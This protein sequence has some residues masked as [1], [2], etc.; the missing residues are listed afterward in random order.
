A[1]AQVVAHDPHVERVRVRFV[2]TDPPHEHLVAPR[3]VGGDR[4]QTLGRI[5]GDDHAGGP[6]QHRAALVRAQVL[7]GLYVDRLRVTVDHGDANAGR[8]DPQ[9][10]KAEDL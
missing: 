5:V 9:L 7:P 1:L 2:A 6:R 10:C 4:V 8:G 3:D